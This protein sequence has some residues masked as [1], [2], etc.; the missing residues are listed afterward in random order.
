MESGTCIEKDLIIG[1]G[2]GLVQ[3]RGPAFDPGPVGQSTELVL[4]SSGKD[5]IDRDDLVGR[6]LYAPLVTDGANGTDQ[7]LIGSHASGDAIHD[8]AKLMFIHTR[9]SEDQIRL[10]DRL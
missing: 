6:D 3:V 5:R 1:I 8:N 9:L 4:V 7:V 10:F 2:Q